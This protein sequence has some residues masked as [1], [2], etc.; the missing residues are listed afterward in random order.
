MRVVAMRTSVTQGL[1]VGD[2]EADEAAAAPAPS[3]VDL[4]SAAGLAPVA[5]LVQDFT[6][7]PRA[8]FVAN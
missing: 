8:L 7:V 1:R 6:E 5:A 2:A 4:R 3:G